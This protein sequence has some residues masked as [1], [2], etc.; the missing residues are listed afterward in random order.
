MSKLDKTN[1]DEVIRLLE[2]NVHPVEIVKETGV[3]E[4]QVFY[5]KKKYNIISLLP[6]LKKEKPKIL[7]C[8]H[9]FW[10][11]KCSLCGEILGSERQVNPVQYEIVKKLIN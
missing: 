10:V 1:E 4:R 2:D 3:S 9:S 8:E 5:I 6:K 11:M 7:N